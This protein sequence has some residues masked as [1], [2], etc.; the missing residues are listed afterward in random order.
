MRFVPLAMPH[1]TPGKLSTHQ[2]L[3]FPRALEAMSSGKLC[4]PRRGQ[5]P[6]LPTQP[7]L[8]EGVT[9]FAATPSISIKPIEKML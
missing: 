3:N 1:A 4:T 5:T 9:A 2:V 6:H 7:Q 8:A